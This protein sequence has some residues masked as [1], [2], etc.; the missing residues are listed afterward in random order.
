MKPETISKV[1]ELLKSKN[2]RLVEL[3]GYDDINL[4]VAV[5]DDQFPVSV[6]LFAFYSQWRDKEDKSVLPMSDPNVVE[7]KSRNNMSLPESI[8]D[9]QPLEPHTEEQLVESIEKAINLLD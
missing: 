5:F 3:T 8:S 2:L 1:E 6:A 7:W 4:G 9:Y